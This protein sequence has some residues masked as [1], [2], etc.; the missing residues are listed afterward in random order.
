M[1]AQIIYTYA[2]LTTVLC[3]A[4]VQPL[5]VAFLSELIYNLVPFKNRFWSLFRFMS[6]VWHA[7]AVVAEC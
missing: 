2:A 7:T 6:L 4:I 3:F 5:L 1:R